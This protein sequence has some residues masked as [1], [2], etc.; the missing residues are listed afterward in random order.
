MKRKILNAL[1]QTR[2][3]GW[4]KRPSRNATDMRALFVI[5][6]LLI[7]CALASSITDIIEAGYRDYQQRFGQKRSG[8]IALAQ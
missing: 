1:T 5:T 4:K 8:T 2:N 7:S 6:A 3:G